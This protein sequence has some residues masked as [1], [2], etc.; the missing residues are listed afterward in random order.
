MSAVVLKIPILLMI[1]FFLEGVI[2]PA[3]WWWGATLL[4]AA[5]LTA[6]TTV[7][8]ALVSAE[9]KVALAYHSVENVGIILA[10]LGLAVLFS[11][12][13]FAGRPAVRAAASIALMAC[14]FHVVNHAIFKSLLFLG[15][16]SIERHVGPPILGRLGGLIG[17]LPWTAVTMLVGATAIAGLPPLN[18][19][20]SEWLTVQALFGGQ[21]AYSAVRPD[22]P[23][24]L[25]LMIVL[26]VALVALALAFAMTALAFAKIGGEALLGQPRRELTISPEPWSMRLP[27]LLLAVLCVALGLQPWLLVPW[28]STAAESVGYP[29]AGLVATP[30]HIAVSLPDASI[31]GSAAYD[32]SLPMLPLVL[33]VVLPLLLTAVLGTRRWARRPAWVGGSDLAP[34]GVQYEGSTL[35]ALLW[36]RLSRTAT[37]APAAVPYRVAVTPRR[38]VTE[39]SN[40]VANWLTTRLTEG[41]SAFGRWLQNGDVRRYLSYILTTVIVVLVVLGVSS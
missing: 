24:A 31:E 3:Q 21:G 32:A 11:D 39:L 36:H 30:E 2:G 29:R 22:E 18:G 9:L 14:L 19:F 8:Y 12:A 13:Q 28:L 27:M 10:G 20:V 41:S 26:I 17:R 16:G 38:A 4:A 6:V 15:I 7:F 37:T 40:G 33:L 25:L 35:T 1:R 34:A 23:T 5:S